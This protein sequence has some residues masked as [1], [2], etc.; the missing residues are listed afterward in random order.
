MGPGRILSGIKDVTDKVLSAV[1]KFV[2][3]GSPE[4]RSADTD[5]GRGWCFEFSGVFGIWRTAGVKEMQFQ[6]GGHAG[7]L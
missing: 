3:D 7:L 6:R 2:Q 1:A 4:T 5:Q